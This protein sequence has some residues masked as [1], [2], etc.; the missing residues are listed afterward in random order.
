MAAGQ[1]Q[2]DQAILDLYFQ[3]SEEAIEITMAQY[4]ALLRSLAW[5]IL[6]DHEDVE[7]CVSDT[8]LAA[9]NAIPPERP[10]YFKAWLCRIVRNRALDKVRARTRDKRGGGQVPLILEEME[11]LLAGDSDVAR[12]VEE[13]ELSRMISAYLREQPD[14]RRIIFLKRYYFA[15]SIKEI[16]GEQAMTQGAVKV[17]LHRMRRELKESLI[18][19]GYHDQ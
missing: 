6:G 13:E 7:E 9:W 17:L 4:G 14:K 16:A 3:R 12:A 15:S 10:Q 1:E 5:N 11:D 8:Y 2:S 19:Q 18:E